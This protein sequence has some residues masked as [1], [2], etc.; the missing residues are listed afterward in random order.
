MFGYLLSLAFLFEFPAGLEEEGERERCVG[1]VCYLTMDFFLSFFF[2]FFFF[3]LI[4]WRNKSR[5][6][7]LLAVRKNPEAGQKIDNCIFVGT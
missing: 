2:C 6:K 5:I 4:S 7:M 1:S 3:F